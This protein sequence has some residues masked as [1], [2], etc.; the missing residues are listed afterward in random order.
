MC[1]VRDKRTILCSRG[2][3]EDDEMHKQETFPWWHHW[4]ENPHSFIL[5][6]SN[7]LLTTSCKSSE[8]R[9]SV[10]Q[11]KILQIPLKRDANNSLSQCS[12]TNI[13]R[14]L[15]FFSYCTLQHRFNC[16]L[17]KTQNGTQTRYVGKTTPQVWNWKVVADLRFSDT[18][19]TKIGFVFLEQ[20]VISKSEILCNLLLFLFEFLSL[21]LLMPWRHLRHFSGYRF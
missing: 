21:L 5:Q 8:S 9:L 14:R 15:F 3:R 20:K 7:A 11:R 6:C 19:C 17:H 16:L 10:L 13:H 18:Q 1:T 2:T 4:L 12:K